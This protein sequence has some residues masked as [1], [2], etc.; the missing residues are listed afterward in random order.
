MWRMFSS[1]PPLCPLGAIRGRARPS[2]LHSFR[3]VDRKCTG[4][5]KGP[6]K[7]GQARFMT[8]AR[9]KDPSNKRAPFF[10]PSNSALNPRFVLPADKRR[11]LDH[12]A[13][14][15]DFRPLCACPTPLRVPL[16]R[17]RPLCACLGAG[18]PLLTPD[19]SKP[20]EQFKVGDTLLSS[21]ED[22]P[23]G[24]VTARRVEKV[25]ERVSPLI[26]VC[27]GGRTIRT[28]VEHPFYVQGRSGK[29]DITDY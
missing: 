23:E 4:P 9:I 15:I 3:V 14:P 7:E 16:A 28:T 21:P 26:E 1:M 29:G 13:P 19:G 25:F 24:A 6:G 20:I 11:R 5:G 27:L 17:A 22:D 18:T 2:R 10:P 8:M 12:E